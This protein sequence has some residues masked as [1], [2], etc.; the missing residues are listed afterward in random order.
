MKRLTSKQVRLV[1]SLIDQLYTAADHNLHVI[2]KLQLLESLIKREMNGIEIPDEQDW[3]E[4]V[5]SQIR[6]K[7]Q[8]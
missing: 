3:N 5:T 6:A 7:D 4:R 8:A 1:K 2:E